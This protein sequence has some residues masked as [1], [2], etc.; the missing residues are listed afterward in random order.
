[1]PARGRG[2]L[3][4]PSYPP[5]FDYV[6]KLLRSID[7]FNVDKNVTRVF[8]V[9]SRKDYDN[10]LLGLYRTINIIVFFLEDIIF[11]VF[12]NL[13]DSTENIHGAENLINYCDKFSFQ[14]IKKILSV[15]YITSYLKYDF[16]YVMDS[17]G[18]FIRPFSIDSIFSEH[19]KDR[20]IFY[21]SDSLRDPT[22]P[23]GSGKHCFCST[24]P[25]PGSGL[26]RFRCAGSSAMRKIR[27]TLSASILRTT[28]PFPGWPLEN[29][30]WIYEKN[31]VDDFCKFVFQN[32]SKTTD[33]AG[34]IKKRCF[35]EIVY[36]HFI[37]INNNKYGY[38]F[39]D[40]YEAMK[41]YLNNDQLRAITS[42][43]Y[44][45]LEDI[46]Y[47]ITYYPE[48]APHIS[49]FFKCYKIANFKILVNNTNIGFVQQNKSIV[50]I[51][52]G[53]FPVN[54][55]LNDDE[56]SRE[57]E[58]VEFPGTIE[59]GCSEVNT[60]VVKLGRIYPSNTKLYFNHSHKDT[61]TYR[62]N[63]DELVVTR[64]DE[65]SGWGQN[66]IG[67]QRS[68]CDSEMNSF[69][70]IFFLC[71]NAR[72]FYDCFDSAYENII[73]KLFCGNTQ[74]NTHVLFYLKCDDPGPKGQAGWDFTYPPLD[75]TVLKEYISKLANKHNNI[76]FHSQVLP[77]NKITDS[78]LLSQ[79]KDRKQYIEFLDDDDKLVRALHCHYNI[80]D[81]GKI[82]N[83]IELDNKVSFDFYIYIRPDL[84][85]YTPCRSI[86]EYVT[87]T[88][89]VILG[90]R[91][92]ATY[93]N[94]H[95]AIIPH[96]YRNDFFFERMNLIRT[97]DKIKF[98]DSEHIYWSTI[99]GKY[100][101]RPIGEYIIKREP[102][103]VDSVRN[104][105]KPVAK[106]ENCIILCGRQH[107]SCTN[108]VKTI[109]D[110]LDAD[111]FLVYQDDT[112]NYSSHKNIRGKIKVYDD[113]NRS[114]VEN[115][116]LKIKEGWLLMEKYEQQNN[117]EYESVFRLRGD[118]N[119][120]LNKSID[121]KMMENH[122]YLNS[123]FLFYGLRNYVKCCF[124]LYDLWSE[125]RN[126]NQLYD[127]EIKDVINTIKNNPSE[128]FNIKKWKYLNKLKAFPIPI[129]KG[130]KWQPTDNYSKN[131]TL[132]ILENLS[133]VYKNYDDVL[134]TGKYKLH[135]WNEQ[136]RASNF[137]CELSILQI[138]LN[139][140]IV[141]VNSTFIKTLEKCD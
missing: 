38:K 112:C 123:D 72:T 103:G 110:F 7:K 65:K 37:F 75:E 135:Y 6:K 90:E 46:R 8:L 1:M 89:K 100:I 85:F 51:N 94:D 52:S 116:F 129:L 70:R 86:S 11:G 111:L 48:V 64:T 34:I 24:Y 136:D 141:P 87:N 131:D 114:H 96:K 121:H 66:L 68:A 104:L 117:C 97:N 99:R 91:T 56:D 124:L 106:L 78:Q 14:S 69:K 20:R 2:C 63:N 54:F 22:T 120:E 107:K 80:E 21:N 57:R 61:F 32:V 101:A 9:V 12:D 26:G 47:G 59:I 60:K 35:V 18:I 44:S 27:H 84:F 13:E 137:P 81:C 19:A 109:I 4:I 133:K 95:L 83:Q 74:K 29:Y 23:P 50:C 73:D 102:S 93:S 115:Q 42:T 55:E 3:M 41:D 76:R 82:I 132:A 5:H 25:D 128:C 39:I 108:N 62:F 88:D 28:T 139:K 15:K 98:Q 118:I 40:T 92:T 10:S 113:P 122:V 130:D 134:E 16:V 53:D 138:L 58:E 17:E 125:S 45:L 31:I 49:A 71:G 127:I 140:N 33:L 30:S 77:T 119:Y 67:Y 126:N 43:C 79:V 36:Y 105:G